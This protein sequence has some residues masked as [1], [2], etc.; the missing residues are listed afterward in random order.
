MLTVALRTQKTIDGSFVG[1]LRFVIE[2][3]VQL[4]QRRRKSCEIETNAP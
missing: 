3:D 1:T 4:L 2:K